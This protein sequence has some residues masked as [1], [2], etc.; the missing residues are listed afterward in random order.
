[1]R[2]K[3][4]RKLASLIGIALVIGAIPIAR[5]APDGF[6][7]RWIQPLPFFLFGSIFLIYGISGRAWPSS[8]N[9]NVFSEDDESNDR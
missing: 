5:Y 7:P 3:V 4:F 8:Y 2:T 6:W 9:G 1:M